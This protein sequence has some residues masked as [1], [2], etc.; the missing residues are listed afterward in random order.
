VIWVTRLAQLNPVRS[1][2]DWRPSQLKRPPYPTAGVEGVLLFLVEA[3]IE[4]VKLGFNRL[5]A[6][7]LRL[8]YFFAEREPAGYH[9]GLG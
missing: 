3:G 6:I 9:V 1:P 8:G 7:E 5:H 4:R 2:A